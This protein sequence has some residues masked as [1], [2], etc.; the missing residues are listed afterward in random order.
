MDSGQM[1]NPLIFPKHLFDRFFLWSK[2]DLS[3]LYL[4][5]KRTVVT[6]LF[7]LGIILAY[8][9]SL[10]PWILWPLRSSYMHI[11]SVP[12]LASLFMSLHLKKPIFNRTDFF[13]PTISMWMLLFMMAVSSGRN[14]NGLFMVFFSTIVY[15]SLFKVDTI[16]LHKLCD[17]IAMMMATILSVSIPFYILY[18]LGYS[19]PHSRIGIGDYMFDNYLFFLIDDRSSW[20]LIPRFHSIFIEPS[21]LGMACVT[22]LYAQA[23][24]WNTWRCRILF[25]A[26]FMSFSLAAYACMVVMLFSVSWMKGKAVI[27]KILLLGSIILTIGVSSVFYNKGDNLINNLIVNRLMLDEDGEMEGN[28]RT[29]DLFTREYEKLFSSGEILI[30][31]GNEE[32]SKF[33]FGNSGYRVFIYC[34]G[35]ISVVC[36]CFMFFAI[37]RTST[38]MRACISML[39]IHGLSFW[40]HGNPHRLYVYF[41]LYVLLF[42]TVYPPSRQLT[43]K[44]NDSGQ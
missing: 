27:G 33:G 12:I 7:F 42:S 36:L 28:N 10:T 38:N 41:P 32:L 16:E 20:E 14:I 19:L 30:G 34:N 40:A 43:D 1:R 24:K 6:W 8:F 15:F 11:A 22:L 21:H 26:L 9:T 44:A 13:L 5:Q 37:A 25:L 3:K 35:L 17:I 39:I 23:G 29:T 2:P 4:I 18:L 31:K